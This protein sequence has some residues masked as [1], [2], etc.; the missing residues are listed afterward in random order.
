MTHIDFMWE[1]NQSISTRLL[2]WAQQFN[3]FLSKWKLFRWMED[4]SHLCHCAEQGKSSYERDPQGDVTVMV[5]NLGLDCLQGWDNLVPVYYC[6]Y[7]VVLFFW[8]QWKLTSLYGF[9]INFVG[10]M[11]GTGSLR[12]ETR[13]EAGLIMAGEI[14]LALVTNLF[15]GGKVLLL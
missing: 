5:Y 14:K 4:S 2:S 7:L 8:N 10:R 12:D 13:E 3:H 9:T 11:C 15:L 6:Q 1:T